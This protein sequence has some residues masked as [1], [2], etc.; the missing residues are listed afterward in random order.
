MKNAL[1]FV[2]EHVEKCLRASFEYVRCYMLMFS[3]AEV[4]HGDRGPLERGD[5]QGWNI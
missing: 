1:K 5:F 3:D 2:R 4:R